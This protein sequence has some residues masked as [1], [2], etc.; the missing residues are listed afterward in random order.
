MP[1]RI[2]NEI[3]ALLLKTSE[4]EHGRGYVAFVR[5]LLKWDEK[6]YDTLVGNSSKR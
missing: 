2:Q 5:K 6:G 1:C 4:Q 3:E